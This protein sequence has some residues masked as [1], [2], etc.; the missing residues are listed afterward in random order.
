[1]L[2]T[3]RDEEAVCQHSGKTSLSTQG[4]PRHAWMPG[5]RCVGGLTIAEVHEA[6]QWRAKG[7]QQRVNHQRTTFIIGVPKDG[8]CSPRHRII[9][10]TDLRPCGVCSNRCGIGRALL[11]ESDGLHKPILLCVQRAEWVRIGIRLQPTGWAEPCLPSLAERRCPC[12]AAASRRQPTAPAASIRGALQLHRLSSLWCP[13]FPTALAKPD[14]RI[15]CALGAQV[16]LARG[17][18]AVRADQAERHR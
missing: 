4:H 16:S 10:A 15:H 17:I 6:E 13:R 1:M 3:L 11:S 8:D 2:F 12:Q 5:K 9:S 14:A 7:M 18:A